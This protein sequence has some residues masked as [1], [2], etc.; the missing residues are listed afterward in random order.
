VVCLETKK[1]SCETAKDAVLHA[2]ETEF[3]EKGLYGAR[4]DEIARQSGVNKRII[5]KLFTNKEELYKAV[6]YKAYGKTSKAERGMFKDYKTCEEGLINV[7]RDYFE[8]LDSNPNYISLILW[9]NLN[10][11]EYVKEL[12]FSEIKTKVVDYIGKIIEDGKKNG[13]FKKEVETDQVV[14]SVMTFTFSYFSN[15]YTLAKLLQNKID[16]KKDFDKRIKNVTEM[17]LTYIKN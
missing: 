13:E 7:I 6:L 17:I 15:K 9:E 10:K 8:F 3:A 4:V 16:F 14:L 2:A 5:Y 11:G 12:D 1:C